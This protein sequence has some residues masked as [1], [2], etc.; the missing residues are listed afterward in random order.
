MPGT[1]VDGPRALRPDEWQQ[2]QSLVDSTFGRAV[3]ADYP[4]LFNQANRPNLRVIAVDGRVVS[5]VGFNRRPATLLGC[6]VDVA[7][8]GG[9][10][11]ASEYRGRGFASA[12]FEDACAR[13]AAGGAD[14]M[15]VS[16]ARGLYRRAGC[17][18]VGRDFE[19]ALTPQYAPR[20][21]S[22]GEDVEVEAVTSASAATAELAPLYLTE[23]VRFLRPRE[24]WEWALATGCV[25][26]RPS[27]FVAL[28]RAGRAGAYAVVWRP[29]PARTG[30]PAAPPV[31]RVAEYA[32]DRSTLVAGLASLVLRY[33]V[34]RL[35]L[36]VAAWDVVL[37]SILDSGG[38][39]ASPAPAW[40]TLR[41]VN[42][43]QLIDRLRPHFAAH[44]GQRF[45]DGLSCRVEASTGLAEGRFG[46]RHARQEVVVGG[47]GDLAG[48]L[49]GSVDEAAATGATPAGAASLQAQLAAALPLPALWYGLNHA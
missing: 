11:T 37:R 44:L 39:P 26:D 3:Y 40:G 20:L 33:R 23:P 36:H 14:L 47:R 24:D 7:C 35:V 25:M 38:V 8:V 32:G 6:R 34:S 30:R 9:V 12:L 13:A 1:N 49:F 22:L 46:L 15:L 4:Q 41:I 18:R 31:T 27:E 17:R 21:R 42:A 2:V 16:G 5:H 28:R 43:A 48:Y 29:A 19:Y 10:A 45:A